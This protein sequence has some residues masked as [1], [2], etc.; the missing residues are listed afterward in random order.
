MDTNYIK[1]IPVYKLDQAKFNEQMFLHDVS[2]LTFIQTEDPNHAFS[3]LLWKYESCVRRHMPLKKLNNKEK[4]SQQKP[5]ITHAILVKINHRNE[6]FKKSKDDPGNAHLKQVYNRFRNSVNKDIK[7]SKE[8]YYLGYFEKCKNNMKKTW[9]GINELIRSSNKSSTIN[10]IHHNNTT[11][12]DPTLMS[13]TYNNFF[14]NVGPEVDKSIPKTPIS[15]LS[16]LRNRV[17]TNFSFQTTNITKVMTTLLLLDDNKSSGPSDIPIKILKIAAPIIIP[18]LVKIFNLSFKK[19]VFPD[20]MKLAK[21]IPIF[22]SG[23]KLLV[24]NYR[25]ISLLSIFSKIFEK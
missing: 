2:T 7:K 4:K 11:I 5:W 13:N 21:V 6:I 19:G 3:E 20:L 22:K 10:Q 25:P 8:Q 9:K 17:L 16:F 23:S 1:N 18:Q 12:N 14:A 15:P 24:T